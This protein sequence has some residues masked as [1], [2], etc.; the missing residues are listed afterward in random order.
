MLPTCA[1][2]VAPSP[3]TKLL[4]ALGLDGQLQLRQGR[5][6]EAIVA[7][8]AGGQE[9]GVAVFVEVVAAASA[10]VVVVLVVLEAVVEW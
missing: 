6:V 4:A 7:A 8:G 3:S 1:R 10:M 5:N 9:G 2:S